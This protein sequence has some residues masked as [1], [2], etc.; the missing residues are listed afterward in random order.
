MKIIGSTV[1]YDANN[2][3]HLVIMVEGGYSSSHIKTK[4][5]KKTENRELFYGEDEDGFVK[6]GSRNIKADKFGHKA[7]YVWSSRASIFNGC[8]DKNAMEVTIIDSENYRYAGNI[9][10]EK[11]LEL[12]NGSEYHIVQV[13]EN[14]TDGKEI[15]YY[16][17][18]PKETK[19]EKLDF[20]LN[21]HRYITKR[22]YPA[23]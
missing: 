17:S 14:Y 4:I 5:L 2:M 19:K 13:T 10:V 1:E 6:Y 8:F 20:Y 7:G 21:E 3:L 22:L 9:T 16:I 18:S 15:E 12:L 23:A 11:A